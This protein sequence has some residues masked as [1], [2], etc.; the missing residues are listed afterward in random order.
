MYINNSQTVENYM[1]KQSSN[2]INKS[3]KYHLL[4]KMPNVNL[5]SY[6]VDGLI[7]I[8][9]HWKFEVIQC[10]STASTLSG[11]MSKIP[12]TNIEYNI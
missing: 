1:T 2:W 10:R 9:D 12:K 7:R 6:N 3:L 4:C 11:V 5:E 8:W